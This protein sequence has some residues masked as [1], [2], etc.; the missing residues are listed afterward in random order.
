MMN[1]EIDED[2][3]TPSDYA[4][5]VKNVPK[6]LDVNYQYELTKIFNGEAV[7]DTHIVVTNVDLVYDATELFEEEEKMGELV[8]EK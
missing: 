6:G 7:P 4:I 3:I 8:K 2:F 1:I 5:M